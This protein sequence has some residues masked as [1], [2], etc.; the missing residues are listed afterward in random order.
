[1]A[2]ALIFTDD[3]LRH[4]TGNHPERRE[5]Y[6]AAL[7]GLMEDHELWERLVKLLPRPATDQEIL[8][9]HSEGALARVLE[10]AGVDRSALDA[11]TM[12]SSDSA[13]VARLAAGGACR[14]VDAVVNGEVTSAFVA[15]R[16]PGHHATVGQDRKSV[17]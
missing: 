14:A 15:C 1:M 2:T 11:D 6:L 17:V 13:A 16:P 8:R 5:R 7:G 3:F 9:C 10:T 12:V 4:D